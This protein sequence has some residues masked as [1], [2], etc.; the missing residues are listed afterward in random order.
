MKK[1]SQEENA[2]VL[3]SLFAYTEKHVDQLV[4]QNVKP[5]EIQGFT[6]N[7]QLEAPWTEIV[8]HHMKTAL[9]LDAGEYEEA[10]L[11]QKEV[12]Q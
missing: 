3:A 9:Y 8:I 1:S 12:V 4:A 6:K 11:S 5:H 2:R 7:V 10:F